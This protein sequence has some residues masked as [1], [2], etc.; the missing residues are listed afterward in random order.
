MV[1][2]REWRG[3]RNE[4][5]SPRAVFAGS[6]T[7]K[8]IASICREYGILTIDTDQYYVDALQDIARE[9]GLT[10]CQVSLTER[11]KTERYIGIRAKLAERE[12]ELV[13]EVRAD[14]IRLRKRVTQAG[15]AVVLPLS[16]DGRHCDFAPTVM[17]GLGRWMK[18]EQAVPT[19]PV[20]PEEKRMLE[21][22]TRRYARPREDWD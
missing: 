5:L 6:E 16:S 4:P 19:R 14:L 20:D 1:L 18:D 21:Q 11:E 2:G 22:A 15:I 7:E 17:L 3:S 10:L 13:P 8:G 9:S 12:I